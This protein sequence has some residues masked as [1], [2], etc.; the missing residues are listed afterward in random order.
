MTGAQAPQQPSEKPLPRGLYAIS[1]NA[2]A[3][4][5]RHRLLQALPHAVAENGFEGMTVEHVVK[6]GQVRR[7]AFYEQFADKR[8]CFTAAYEIAQE[9]LLGVLTFQCYTQL[10]LVDRVGAALSAGLESLG[11]NPSVARMIVIEA[12]AAGGEISARHQEWL[13]RYSRLLQLAA[14]GSPD[15]AVPRPALESAIVGSIVSRIK[16]LVLAGK[17]KDLPRLCPELAQLTVSYYGSAEPP[18]DPRRTSAAGEGPES[19][20]PQSPGRRTVLELA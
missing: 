14:V 9:R 2:V 13:D 18:P 10:G 11:A 19:A 15:V 1:A 12:P 5:Q 3:A 17:T 7:N 4:D 8:D 16:Q 20:Q 6:L